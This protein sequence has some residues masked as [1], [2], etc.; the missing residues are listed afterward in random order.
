VKGNLAINVVT[1]VKQDDQ[2]M[3]YGGVGT[4]ALPSSSIEPNPLRGPQLVAR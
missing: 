4:V 2:V 1:G 3:F